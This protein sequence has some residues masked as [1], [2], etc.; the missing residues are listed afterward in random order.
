MSVQ[1]NLEI[2]I[3]NKF[4]VILSYPAMIVPSLTEDDMKITILEAI[5]AYLEDDLTLATLVSL[6]TTIQQY[7]GMREKDYNELHEGLAQITS[8][9]QY[10]NTDKKSVLNKINETLVD[11]LDSFSKS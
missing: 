2:Q 5:L 8:L 6:A 11:A 9:S 3:Q 1:S 4:Q 7:M 10:L